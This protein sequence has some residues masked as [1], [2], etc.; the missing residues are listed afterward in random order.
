MNKV[1]E[2]FL[3]KNISVAWYVELDIACCRCHCIFAERLLLLLPKHG[4]IL[5]QDIKVQLAKAQLQYVRFRNSHT[6]Y[7]PLIMMSVVP[8][9]L[10]IW[11]Q[12]SYSNNIEHLP[13][14]SAIYSCYIFYSD[15]HSNKSEEKIC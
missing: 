15:I 12:Y 11:V 9:K 10:Q 14:S 4:H 7:I 3:I 5:K 1:T 13:I 6:D 2:F 8:K